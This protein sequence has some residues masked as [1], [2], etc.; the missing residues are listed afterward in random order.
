MAK[1]A[2]PDRV[3]NAGSR[4]CR[5][6]EDGFSLLEVLVAFSILALSTGVTMQ[7][8]STGLRKVEISRA[9]ARALALAEATLA[10]VGSDIPLVPGERLGEAPGQGRDQR[11]RWRLNILPFEE[12]R[13]TGISALTPAPLSVGTPLS[14]I[15]LLTLTVSV[16]WDDGPRSRVLTLHSARISP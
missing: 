1:P 3:A 7:I 11:Y 12:A 8:F 10:A 5:K 15:K 2:S 13:P 4:L 14:P 9:Q 6:A 16:E